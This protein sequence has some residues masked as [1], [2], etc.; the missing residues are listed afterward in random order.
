ME[1]NKTVQISAEKL[2]KLFDAIISIRELSGS[3]YNS[4]FS[5]LPKGVLESQ[6]SL[7]RNQM[8]RAF[9]WFLDHYE[10]TQSSILS[11]HTLSEYAHD[12]LPDDY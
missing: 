11:I 1:E 3:I 4:S 8:E 5:N 10:Q 9:R 2:Q 12:Q 6:T 7:G